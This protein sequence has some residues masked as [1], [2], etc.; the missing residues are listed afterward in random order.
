MMDKKDPGVLR[1]GLTAAGCF[2]GA[3][4]VSGQELWKFF[5]SYGA[6]GWVSLAVAL[7]ALSW[8][9]RVMFALVMDM[10]EASILKTF[11]AFDCGWL[12]TVFF[13]L[14]FT[15]LISV[16]MVM[17][18]GSGTQL[19]QMTGIPGWVGSTIVCGLGIVITMSGLRGIMDIFP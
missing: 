13:F 15:F 16:A 18:A 7:I 4:L 2:L 14:Q 10:G 6:W 11:V 19:S 12:R 8:F 1:A 5:G 17:L 9:I 3:G